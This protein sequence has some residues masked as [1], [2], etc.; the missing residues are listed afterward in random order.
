VYEGATAPISAFLSVVPKVAALTVLVRTLFTAFAAVPEWPLLIA[1]AAA[2]TMTLGNLFALRQRSVKRLLGYSTIAQAGYLLMAVAVIRLDALA[3][4]AFVFYLLIYLAMNVPAFIVVSIVERSSGDDHIEQFDGLGTSS[5]RLAAAMTL[6][7]LSLGGIPPLAGFVGKAALFIVA[8]S[9]GFTWLVVI[10]AINTAISIYYY[11]RVIAAMYFE[12]R[13][14]PATELVPKGASSAIAV[15]IG[16][17]VT[18]A[19]GVFPLAFFALAI[20]SS[21]I[22]TR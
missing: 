7:F 18:L 19:I 17:A 4:P 16:T 2:L 15:L 10:A 6:L 22:T 5:P 21:A 13:A 20:A 8:M 1:V 11:L 12:R 3:I 14:G 9:G